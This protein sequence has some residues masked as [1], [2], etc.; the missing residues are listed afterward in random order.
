MNGHVHA[1]STTIIHVSLSSSTSRLTLTLNDGTI[2][3][4]LCIANAYSKFYQI[5]CT[6][7][8]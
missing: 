3:K 5:A 6:L 1:L 7:L 4:S 2:Q 8:C